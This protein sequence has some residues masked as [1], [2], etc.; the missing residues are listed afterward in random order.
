[1]NMNDLRNVVSKD[2][3]L[4]RLLKAVEARVARTVD[5]AIERA[6]GHHEDPAKYPLPAAADSLERLLHERLEWL[7]RAR[8]AAIVGAIR[9][10]LDEGAAARRARYHDLADLDPRDRASVVDQVRA[11]SASGLPTID[12]ASATSAV[13]SIVELTRP[14]DPS[15]S[16]DRVRLFLK[17]AECLE[18][19]L[20]AFEG[21]DEIALA[22]V[23]LDPAKPEG[24][25]AKRVEL[26]KF[27]KGQIRDFQATSLATFDVAAL[28]GAP[29]LFGAVL[30]LSEE[31]AG[32]SD[33]GRESFERV[34]AGIILGLLA[35]ILLGVVALLPGVG[36][37]IAGSTLLSILV[38]AGMLV[39]T[40]VLTDL[41]FDTLAA[42]ISDDPFAP[43][44]IPI[45]FP[46]A[47][48]PG[49]SV[50]FTIPGGR[51]RYRLTY[52]VLFTP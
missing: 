46:L 9:P 44:V 42:W 37:A 38:I 41:F 29:A 6:V 21:K 52:D 7:P 32:E 33:G 28:D 2:P 39:L 34:V 43:E 25:I 45:P 36:A 11:R 3:E 5:L 17:R 27:K 30:L 15:K 40:K 26:G 1:M 12:V 35:A 14:L 19:T 48:S 49:G 22:V 13:E 20:E 50:T 23:P 47:A 24:G 8:R 4:H 10:R 16:F 31:D 18:E 51:G